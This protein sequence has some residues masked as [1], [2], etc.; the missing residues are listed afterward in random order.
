MVNTF[1]SL[2]GSQAL[3]L[4]M[5]HT[6]LGRTADVIRT[7]PTCK[8]LKKMQSKQSNSCDTT[9]LEP[10]SNRTESPIKKESPARQASFAVSKQNKITPKRLVFENSYGPFCRKAVGGFSPRVGQHSFPILDKLHE[11]Q[12]R[13]AQPTPLHEIPFF[14]GV[15]EVAPKLAAKKGELEKSSRNERLLTSG[16]LTTK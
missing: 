10:F 6:L 5:R 14:E 8:Q 2:K 4:T 16:S 13:L 1:K 7:S 11:K 9:L 12:E 15:A 3:T